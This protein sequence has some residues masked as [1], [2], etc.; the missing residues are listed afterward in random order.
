MKKI[1]ISVLIALLLIIVC[2]AIFKG[3]SF[4]KIKSIND[5]KSASNKLDEDVETANGLANQEY[6][7]KVQTLE[8]T[9]KNLK[10]AKQEYENKNPYNAEQLNI[11]AVEVKNYKIHYLWTIL[12]NY[13]KDEGVRSINLDLKATQNKDVYDLQFT[14]VGNYV[15]ITD[16]LYD[17]EDDEELKFQIKDLKI[18]RTES[19]VATTSNTAT[20]T[21]T[22]SVAN[23]TATK[24]NTNTNTTKDPSEGGTILKATFTVQNIGITLD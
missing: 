4:A 20:N 2:F 1:L 6:P 21:T 13:R 10:L 14:L 24:T 7:S 3:I 22:N 17:I 19:K 15:S 8:E 18:T 9:I 23:T 5:I 11:A 16:F 12:G